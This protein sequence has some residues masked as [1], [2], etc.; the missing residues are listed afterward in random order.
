MNI[1]AILIVFSLFFLGGV[2]LFQTGKFSSFKI[3]EEKGLTI[4]TEDVLYFNT[5]KGFLAAPEEAGTYPGV[6]MIHEWWGLNENIK[7]TAEDLAKEG[8]IV[9]AVDLYN[10]NVAMTREDAQKFRNELKSKEAIANLRA[11]VAFLKEKEAEKIA[12]LGWCFGG[13]KSL[14]LALSGEDLDATVIYYG[15]LVT[16]TEKLKTITW[17]ILGIFGEEDQ[18]I[19]TSTV[20]EFQ[21]A[22]TTLDIESEVYVYPGVGH[23]FANPSGDSFAPEETKDAW[24]KTLLFLERTLKTSE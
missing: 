24:K 19:S 15:N 10:G 9:L 3:S 5:V 14:E 23:A 17:P 7:K 11:A 6:V 20:S 1:K 2:Y 18:S 22:L 8:Y 12:S 4:F 13:G 21:D 16:D